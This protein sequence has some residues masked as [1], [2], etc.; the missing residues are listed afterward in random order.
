MDFQKLLFLAHRKAGFTYYDFVPYHY[1]C[2]SFQAAA[3]LETLQNLGWLDLEDNSIRLLL[4]L[5]FEKGLSRDETYKMFRFMQ[6]H[7]DYRSR[8]L[9]RHICETYP[10]YAVKSKMARDVLAEDAFERVKREKERFQ[11]Q[12]FA[13]FTIGY[14]DISFEAYVNVLIKNDVHLLCDVRKNPH[15]RKFGFSK[16]ALSSLLPK[17]GIQY[18][19]IPELGIVSGSRKHLKAEDDYKRLFDEYRTSIP[20]KKAHLARLFEQ[21]RTHKRA[22][23]TCFEKQASFCHRHCVSDYLEVEKG[24]KAT[25]L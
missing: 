2:Y 4:D 3:D 17:L 15:S 11:S 1:G 10:Y 23:L 16:G 20:Q 25:H 24:A 9:V 7:K 22:A 13:L 21:I 5:P 8:K 18:L 14:E 12:E 19:H 6:S